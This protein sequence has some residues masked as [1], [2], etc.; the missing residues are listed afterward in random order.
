MNKTFKVVMKEQS[1][2]H[3]ITRTAVCETRQQVVDWYG[4][5]EPDIE[6]YHITEI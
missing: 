3:E 5:N 6:Y 2:D 1:S 4:L